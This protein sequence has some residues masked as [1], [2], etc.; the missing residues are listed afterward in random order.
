ML[1]EGQ[2]WWEVTTRHLIPE[3]GPKLAQW[4]LWSPWVSLVEVCITKTGKAETAHNENMETRKAGLCW[5]KLNRV[6]K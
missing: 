3:S 6:V 4:L 5:R 2:R 1:A